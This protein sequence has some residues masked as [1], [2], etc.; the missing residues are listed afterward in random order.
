M[1]EPKNLGLQVIYVEIVR[2]RS[3]NRTIDSRQSQQNK[4]QTTCRFQF[5]TTQLSGITINSV[6]PTTKPNRIT[7]QLTK[8]RNIKG[9]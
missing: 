6:D 7:Q 4:N 2:R 3:N 1:Y 8:T 5:P 9:N